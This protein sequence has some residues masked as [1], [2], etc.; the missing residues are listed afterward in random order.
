MTDI[1]RLLP[2]FQWRNQSYPVSERSVTFAHE[3]AP[4]RIQFRN[5]EFREMTGARAFAFNYRLPMREGIAKGP[6]ANLFNRGLNVLLRDF[7]DKSPGILI[8]PIYGT[9]RCVPGEWNDDTDINRRDGT[10]IRISFHHS[11]E[12][13]TKEPELKAEII[14]APGLL[15]E[16]RALEQDVQRVNWQQEPSPEPNSDIFGAISGAA[17]QITAQADRVAAAF[18]DLAF[19][20]EKTEAALDRL[21]NPQNWRLRDSVRRN[22]E[23]AVR[24]KRNYGDPAKKVRQVTNNYARTLSVIAAEAGMTV[25]ELLRLNPGL[26]KTPLVPPGMKLFLNA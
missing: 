21:E 26:A 20:L 10:D 7:L 6:Y 15:G 5:G 19:R 4:H 9:F 3:A 23:A 25:Q 17:G 11:P 2:R 14:S 1:L 18:D 16:A 24:I 22:R 12:L 8:D 13:G